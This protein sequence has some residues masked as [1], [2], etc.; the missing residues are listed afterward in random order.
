MNGYWDETVHEKAQGAAGNIT[1]EY[2][3]ALGALWDRL[4][5][6]SSTHYANPGAAF[7]DYSLM[8]DEHSDGSPA[9]GDAEVARLCHHVGVMAGM[10][11]GLFGSS[12]SP[13]DPFGPDG[14]DAIEDHFRYHSDADHELDWGGPNIDVMSAEIRWL[15]PLYRRGE[16]PDGGGH[17][18][19]IYGYDKA[20]DPDRLFLMQ[21]G[22]GNPGEWYSC[23]SVPWN[24]DQQY[25]NYI[26]PEVGYVF[27][28]EGSGIGDGSPDAPWPEIEAALLTA[29][30]HSTIIL[31]AGCVATFSAATL[32]IDRPLTLKGYEVTITQEP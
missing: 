32:T 19:V 9:P 12:A 10:D 16:R 26:A 27:A 25:I 15:R 5:S 3:D 4:T 20:T 23:D 6:T 30:D 31:E 8:N 18:W 22:H 24:Q 14:L 29:P 21:I 1:D 28:G 11:Y 7:Y 13:W 17:G 2:L